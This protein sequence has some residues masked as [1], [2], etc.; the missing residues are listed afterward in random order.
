MSFV[1]AQDIQDML[2]PLLV[3][4]SALV[5]R[6]VQAPFP[7]LAYRDAMEWYGSDKPDT[8]CQVR[9]QDVTG[10]FAQSGF[11]LFRAAA[12]SQGQRRVR[13]LFFAGEKAGAYSRKQLDEL[14][15]VA[16]HLGAGG[17]PYAK[18]GKEGLSSSF[19][20]FLDDEAEARAQQMA[21][22]K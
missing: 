6:E 4:L 8:R 9:I 2:E 19:K 11:N 18:W 22:A 5:G 3:E 20:K 1:R 16:K 21:H 10:L 13:G 15:D 17:L 7:R 14:Q 12:E